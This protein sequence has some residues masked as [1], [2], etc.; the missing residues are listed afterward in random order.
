MRRT[1]SISEQKWPTRWAARLRLAAALGLLLAAVP[2][3]RADWVPL[4]FAGTPTDVEAWAPGVYSVS[5]NQGFWY[6][7]VNGGVPLFVPSG[8]PS[9]GTYRNSTTGCFL[10]FLQPGSVVGSPCTP[11]S[12]PILTQPFLQRV[13]A[14]E[15]RAAYAAANE[16][17][18]EAWVGFTSDVSD[19]GAP[20]PWTPRERLLGLRAS[21]GMGVL[22]LGTADDAL[23]AF[24][25]SVFATQL[26]WYRN[27]A[28]QVTFTVPGLGGPQEVQNIDL[29]PGGGTTPTALFGWSDGLRRGTLTAAGG[30]PFTLVPLPDSPWA[31][32]GVDVNTGFGSS[33]HGDGFGM[34]TAVA[35]GRAALM[36][37]VPATVPEEIGTQWRVNPTF[38]P[39]LPAPR[40]VD[41]FGAEFCVVA[42]DRAGA[43]GSPNVLLYTNT[44]APTLTVDPE[45]SVVEGTS[46]IIPI[47]VEDLDG[48]ALRLSVQPPSLDTPSLSVTTNVVPGGVDLQLTGKS[49]CADDSAPITVRVTD[50]LQRHEQ[51]R[52]FSVRVF[53]TRRPSPPVVSASD[54]RLRAGEAPPA[55]TASQP[56]GEVCGIVRYDWSAVTPSARPVMSRGGDNRT[57]DL[58]F[59]DTL[60]NPLGLTYV[61]NVRAVDSAG[62]VSDPTEVIYRVSPWGPPLAPFDVGSTVN[63]KAGQSHTFE[64]FLK[65]GCLGADPA[66]PGV[67]TV[68]E[69]TLGKLPT[70]LVRILDADDN[71]IT[72]TSAVTPTLKVE[73]SKCASAQLGF[74]VWNYTLDGSTSPGPAS[75]IQVNVD[76]ELIP[77]SEARLALT[78]DEPTPERIS[79]RVDLEVINCVKERGL[80]AN[81]RLERPD[82]SLVD[83]DT[84]SVPGD[85]RFLLQ[86]ECDRRSYVV[87]ASVPGVAGLDSGDGSS[88]LLAPEVTVEVPAA[89]VDLTEKE[90]LHLTATCGEGA[91]GRLEQIIPPGP[92]MDRPLVW[93]YLAGPEL[94]QATYTGER[95]DVATRETDFGAL[96]GQSV[97]MRLSVASGDPSVNVRDIPIIAEP[98]VEV[99]RRTERPTGAETDL[100]GV[101]V[102]LRNT[103][104]CGVREVQHQERLEGVDYVPGSARFDGVPVSAELDGDVLVVSGLVLQGEATGRLTYVVRP[105]LLGKQRFEGQVFLRGV[106]ISQPPE[107][108]PASGCG[109]SGGGSGAAALGLAGLA[110][111]LRRRRRS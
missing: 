40:Y 101:S 111:A 99:N 51:T 78:R 44:H 65:H 23:I 14:T 94:T 102:E 32:N 52:S 66:F 60:C 13:K 9:M 61:Y 15:S 19:G 38:P 79:G 53:H 93:E 103:T 11:T 63:L 75:P 83:S 109:C 41:C 42:Q 105:R 107:P 89:T 4:E 1:G 100:I 27:G 8:D 110:A 35:T 92:C 36:S 81:L 55:I 50:G 59:F 77:L 80:R 64:P 104:A 108:G 72:G 73:T 71:E 24:K 39:T 29:F 18:D 90:P 33:S 96:I 48:D 54:I 69:L 58:P 3:A 106:T 5:T 86:R 20:R 97:R 70:P 91:R 7:A 82:G 74:S 95:I 6:V 16:V 17:G 37:A 87:K 47:R 10:S 88:S 67:D 57:V 26:I 31:V 68:W 76:P 46:R 12:T 56:P 30:T 62:L 25:N 28:R 2:R 49:V 85:W 21:K 22:R 45:T 84:V 43:S 98:F 34:A